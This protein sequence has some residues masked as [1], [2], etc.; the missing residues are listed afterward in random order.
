MLYIFFPAKESNW[1][2]KVVTCSALDSKGVD[3]IYEMISE[4]F[5]M[6]K[7][8]GYFYQKRNSQNKNWLFETIDN[9]LKN[10]FYQNDKIQ[11]ALKK[12]NK[13]IE[14][15]EINPFQAAKEILKIK[16]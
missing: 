3:E 2:P 6:T 8:N 11:E 14:S 7:K 10:E 4:Y 13:K 5:I 12:F 15:Q 9:E 1:I 16:R